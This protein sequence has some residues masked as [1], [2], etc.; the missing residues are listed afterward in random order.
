MTTL[1]KNAK[2]SSQDITGDPAFTRDIGFA[3]ARDIVFDAVHE[4][5]RKRRASG[6]TKRKIAE[7]LDRDP[8]WVSRALSGP[9]NWTLRTFGELVEA[10]DGHIE[11]K[12]LPREEIVESNYDFHAEIRERAELARRSLSA[13]VKTL[14][15][16][17]IVNV[18]PATAS[19]N[20]KTFKALELTN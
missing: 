1:P 5:W 10:L 11:V 9:G 13:E 8:A 2:I 16:N 18:A 15:A 3:R 19:A 14:G 6:F 4:L 17:T 7:T 12:V 20:T